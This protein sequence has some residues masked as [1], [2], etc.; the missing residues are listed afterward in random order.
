MPGNSELAIAK[1]RDTARKIGREAEGI[2]DDRTAKAVLAWAKTS[3]SRG[4]IEAMPALARSDLRIAAE[5]SDLDRDPYLLNAPNGTIDLRTGELRP[6]RRED[7]ISHSVRPEYDPKATAPTF[8]RFLDRIT[9]SSAELMEFLQRLAGYAATGSVAEEVAVILYGPGGNGK[10]K[11]T[12]SLQSTLGGYAVEADAEL[13]VR[14][15]NDRHSDAIFHIVGR[16]L[17]IATEA[18]AR[19]KLDER[20]FKQLTGGDMINARQ[21]YAQSRD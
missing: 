14:G 8:L 1:A 7:L 16:R 19:A 6:H 17:V 21:L 3:Q 10:S 4:K 13:L 9:G 15:R 11:F 18:D 2:A 12:G 20:F 5:I